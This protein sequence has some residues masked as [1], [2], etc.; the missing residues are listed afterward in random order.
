MKAKLQE[1][2]KYTFS[3]AGCG[4]VAWT[5]YAVIE[6]WFSSI[7]PIFTQ[8]HFVFTPWHWGFCAILFGLYPVIGLVIG[9]SVGLNSTLSFI[10]WAVSVSSILSREYI[11]F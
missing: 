10:V 8:T 5:V 7:L 1:I 9:G 4:M 6:C 2:R 3:G 11:V